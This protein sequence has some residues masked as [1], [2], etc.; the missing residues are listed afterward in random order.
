MHEEPDQKKPFT[1]APNLDD[2]LRVLTWVGGL[3]GIAGFI[4]V[5]LLW[6]PPAFGRPEWEFGTVGA[7]F[8]A[9]PLFT[10][11]MTVLVV[12]SLARGWRWGVVAA[13]VGSAVAVLVLLAAL[14]LWLL[15]APLAWKGVAPDVRPALLKVMFKTV[16]MAS[17]YLGLFGF[18]GVMAWR[19]VR[20][21]MVVK[22]QGAEP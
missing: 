16:A 3:L 19:R 22:T 9:L 1:V 15:N 5:V 12:A 20:R 7:T 4:D 8:D 17:I 10:L 18:V 21:S 6:V 11:G 13:G 2:A 14:V